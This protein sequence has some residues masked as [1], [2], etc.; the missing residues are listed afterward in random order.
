[1]WYFE[2]VHPEHEDTKR[3]K[4]KVRDKIHHANTNQRTE[5]V[6]YQI[7]YTKSLRQ[8]GSHHN[9]RG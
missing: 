6:Q 9:A 1:M 4:V 3:P 7:K 2:K 8:K 5:I